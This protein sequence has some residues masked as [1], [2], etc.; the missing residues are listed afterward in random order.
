MLQRVPRGTAPLPGAA[1]EEELPPCRLPP[2]VPGH[3]GAGRCSQQ[4]HGPL[5]DHDPDIV[6]QRTGQVGDVTFGDV[7]GRC[8][9]SQ[10]RWVTSKGG[11]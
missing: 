10:G 7:T 4:T 3:P 8:V 1:E 9:T 5:G 6:G 11:G 2:P